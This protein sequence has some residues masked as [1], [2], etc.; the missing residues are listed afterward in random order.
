MTGQCESAK[1]IE[2][3]LAAIRRVQEG[4][5][6]AFAVLLR[7]YSRVVFAAVGRRVPTDAVE[8]VAQEMDRRRDQH[9][10][11]LWRS[12]EESLSQMQPVLTAEQRQVLDGMTLEDLL[13]GP[14]PSPSESD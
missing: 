7:R 8:S 13:P 4:D 11:E 1:G 9:I 12:M 14:P 10:T 3:D 2:T 6:D 5:K